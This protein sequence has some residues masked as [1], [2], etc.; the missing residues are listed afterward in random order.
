MDQIKH[1]YMIILGLFCLYFIY[2]HFLEVLAVIVAHLGEG[3]KA[4]IVPFEDIMDFANHSS[5]RE[6][7]PCKVPYLSY[8][9][10]VFTFWI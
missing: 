4:N 2:K 9:K 8:K 6:R 5:G 3:F 1:I 7:S 10:M